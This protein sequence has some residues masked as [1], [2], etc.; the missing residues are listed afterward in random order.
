MND[1]KWIK[2]SLNM[3]DDEKIKIIESM[4]E[5][6]SIIVIWC[7]LLT[8]T[9]KSNHQGYIMLTDRVAYTEEMLSTILNRN[10]NVVKLA[11]MTFR[12]L[13]MLDFDDSSHAFYLPNWSKYQNVDS[14]DKMKEQNRIRQQK[15][16]DKQ[17]QLALPN[18]NNVTDNVTDNDDLTLNNGSRKKK[19]ERREKKDNNSP[20]ADYASD[21]EE[22]YSLYPRKADKAKALTA[23][24]KARKKIDQSALIQAVTIFSKETSDAGTE[25]RF[26][27]M[28]SS[29]LNAESYFDYVVSEVEQTIIETDAELEARREQRRK[30]RGLL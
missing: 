14:M 9:G 15:Y 13:G 28:P 17:K 7:K 4:P 5:G 19:E 20:K 1:L 22:F 2:F 25:K 21:F 8:L 27:K 29:W 10:P 23:Y 24:K 16:R 26:I 18:E 12:N 3:F 30:E 11:L 6:D